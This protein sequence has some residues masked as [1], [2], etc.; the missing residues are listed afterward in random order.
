[1]S[2]ATQQRKKHFKKKINPLPLFFHMSNEGGKKKTLTYT[3]SP[4][5][6]KEIKKNS[7]CTP[8]LS[9]INK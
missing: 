4:S 2:L 1:L 7:R 9:I 5:R 3:P 6:V 8:S